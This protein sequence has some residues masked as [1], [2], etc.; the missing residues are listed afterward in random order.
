MAA[1]SPEDIA[2]ALGDEIARTGP[3]LTKGGMPAPSRKPG[4]LAG[5]AAEGAGR[6]RRCRRVSLAEAGRWLG[7]GGRRGNGTTF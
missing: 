2:A 4:D 7:H 6:I 1:G 5:I 3:D